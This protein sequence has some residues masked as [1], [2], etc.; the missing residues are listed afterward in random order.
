MPRL[1]VIIPTHNPHVGRLQR[2]LRAL[3]AQTLPADRWEAVL[4]DNV[5]DPALA[6]TDWAAHGPVNLRLVSEPALGL[7]HAR[8]RGFLAGTGDFFVLADD[9]NEL[10]PDYLTE[11]LRLFA[12]HPK[13]GLLG[14][15]SR[16]EFEAP[17]EPWVREFDGL[18][19]CRDLG[20]APLISAGLR[21]PAT[22]RN[23][24]PLFAPIGAGLALRRAAAQSWLDRDGHA[25]LPDR[26]GNDLS[27]SGDNDIVL[28]AM[29]AGWEAAYFPSLRLTHLIPAFRTTRDYLGRLNRGIQRSWMRVLTAHAAN[30][31]PPLA[32]WTV[33]PRR[34][35][36]WFTHRAWSSPAAWVRW[37]GA[38]GH[39]EGRV[40]PA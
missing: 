9:D 17:P 23:D 33:P 39:F 14:G 13:A 36:A 26:R 25:A 15:R 5:S 34:A 20:D 28:A 22:G 2:T 6:A 37:Q 8:R 35:K 27:S 19:A 31:W 4:V 32:P 7:S 40:P 38:C 24:Y 18:I 21:N 16:P 12:A 29:A 1:S 3:Q 11:T 10:A 30:P